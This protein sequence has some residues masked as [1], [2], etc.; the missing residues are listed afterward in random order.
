MFMIDNKIIKF[1]EILNPAPSNFPRQRLFYVGKVLTGAQY[2]QN[3]ES[4]YLRR[5]E[6]VRG[7]KEWSL[8][9][10]GFRKKTLGEH[11][12]RNPCF[13]AGSRQINIAILLS[14]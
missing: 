4:Y 9:I 10:F 11:R 2:L 3:Y 14:I 5:N 13:Y 1:P 6:K 8:K 7:N 12:K